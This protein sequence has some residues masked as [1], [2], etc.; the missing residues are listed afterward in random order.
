MT[1]QL[2]E[3]A[4][5]VGVWNGNSDNTLVSTANRPPPQSAALVAYA[6]RLEELDLLV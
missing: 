6:G 1:D 4:L 3:Y 2:Y 5:A